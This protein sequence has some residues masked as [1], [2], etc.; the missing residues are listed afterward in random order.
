MV[1]ARRVFNVQQITKNKLGAVTF[2]CCGNFLVTMLLAGMLLVSAGCGQTAKPVISPAAGQVYTY[3]GGPFIVAGSPVGAPSAA[4]FDHLANQVAV[5]STIINV[6]S[7]T[8][9]QVPVNTINGSFTSADTGFLAITEYYV[10]TSTGIPSAQNPPITGAWAVEIPGAG[11][12]ANFLSVYTGSTP[13]KISAAPTA[14]AQNTA[15]PNFLAPSPFLYVTIPYAGQITDLVD[16]GVVGISSQGSAVTF[17]TQPYLVGSIP[18][19]TSTVTGAC[20]QTALGALTSYP[21]NTYGTTGPRPELISMGSSGFLVSYFNPG[22]SGGV[23]AFGG[24]TGVIGVAEPSSAL[25]VSSIISAQYNGF[26]FS[27]SNPLKQSNGYDITVLAS[28]FGD[29]TATSQACSVLEASLAA[30]NGQG[31]MVPV[32]PSPNSIY[33]GEF[34]TVTSEGS[35]ND[36]TGAAGSENCDVVIDLGTQ[37]PNH[38]GSFPN[39]TVFI[40][41]NFPPFNA[42]NPWTC[43][44][45]VCAVSFP[46][47]AIVGQVQGQYVIFV[48]ASALSTPPAQLPNGSGSQVQPVGIYLFQKM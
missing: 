42:S 30:N 28:A 48:T 41:S 1:R 39:A 12:L 11:T 21:L 47:A 3:F 24:A 26:I 33:G 27:P 8:P 38:N 36:P 40:G 44:S 25:G 22:P 34:L 19:T 23:G 6:T 2:P 35:V 18:Q 46:A 32:L 15:C 17:S 37:D 10:T 29:Y 4:A 13:P 31:G 5:S 43:S 20:S 7:G 45:G 16:Y 9:V 14:M